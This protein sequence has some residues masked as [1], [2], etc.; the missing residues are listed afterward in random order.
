M[1]KL[2]TLVIAIVITMSCYAQDST[3]L[4]AQGQ[5][6]CTWNSILKD[7]DCH[8]FL[9]KGVTIVLK[10]EVFY[11]NDAYHSKYALNGK[12][13]VTDYDEYN[14]IIFKNVTDKD[15]KNCVLFMI[16][17]IN[18]NMKIYIDYKNKQFRYFFNILN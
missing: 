16:K 6:V 15:G 13:D 9:Y 7:W 5:Q 18:G 11:V 12:G 10:D 4:R 17:Y 3:I 1:K 2:I 8:D 14:I